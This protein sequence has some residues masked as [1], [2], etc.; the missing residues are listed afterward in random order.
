MDLPTFQTF[1]PAETYTLSA[2]GVTRGSD[3]ACIPHDEG[4]ADYR[5]YLAWCASGKTPAPIPPVPFDQSAVSA[6]CKR[7]IVVV[8]STNAQVNMAAARAAG[9]LSSDDETAFADGLQWIVSM[10]AACAALVAAE[11][12][13]YADDSHWPNC[14][15]EVAALAAKF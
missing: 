13:T 7:R 8:A 14:P 3:G 10:R 5:A 11:D 4:N 15:S 2:H 9:M 12:R 6:E 1:D